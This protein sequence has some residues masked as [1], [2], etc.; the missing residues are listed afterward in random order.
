M[1]LSKLL[2]SAL[3]AVGSLRSAAA[4]EP[5]SDALEA[6]QAGGG[7]PYWIANIQRQGTVPFGPAGY[8]VFRNVKEYGA[9]GDGTTDDTE[10]INKAVQDGQRCID[11]CDSRTNAPALVYFPPGTYI[12]SKPI[13]QTYYTQFVGDAVT[14]PT[15]K[16][17]SSFV[18][19]AVI[20][21]N[22][23]GDNG[24]NWYINQNNFFRQVR[25]FVID[26]TA[27]PIED[28][29]GIHWQVSQATSLQ[30]IVI[31]MKPT[32]PTNQQKGLFIENGSGG[33]ITDLVING[34]GYGIY[35]GSQQYTIRN[36][37]INDART[38]VHTIWNWLL[39]LQNININNCEIGVDIS[40][41]GVEEI[42]T[43]S[44]LLMDSKISNTP[45]GVNTL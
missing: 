15:L 11:N 40:S 31:N 42:K 9:K 5:S 45:I 28:G 17:S 8:K 18:G 19:M 30:N 26:I 2:P 21:A 38:G 41:G 36:V 35:I 27:L 32:S 12:V 29:A 10:A 43:G 4:L 39:G 24:L 20:D 16:A 37:T 13:I 3:L 25:N 7:S 23:Y 6:R 44:L 1:W 14:P 22:P 33:F 34:G